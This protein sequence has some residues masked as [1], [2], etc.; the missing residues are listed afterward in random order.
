VGEAISWPD[1]DSSNHHFTQVHMGCQRQALVNL[2]V[3]KFQTGL[4]REKISKNTLEKGILL[5]P[6]FL[7]IGKL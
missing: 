4:E 3:A 1:N 2:Q 6:V 7:A 5:K